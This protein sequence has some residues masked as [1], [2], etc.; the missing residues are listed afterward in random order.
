MAVHSPRSAY[1]RPS[2]TLAERSLVDVLA[3]A[4]V[5]EASRGPI[6]VP[7]LNLGAGKTT[8]I[9]DELLFRGLGDF[10]ADRVDI[11]DCVVEHP[12]AGRAYRCSI[13]EMPQVRS[14]AYRIA[15]SVY[16]LEH[17]PDLQRA[18]REIARVLAPSGLFVATVPNPSALEFLIARH[19]STAFHRRVKS[20]LSGA[21]KVWETHYSY[22][23]V[24]ALLAG[25]ERNG[26]VPVQTA[27]SS[28]LQGYMRRVPVLRLLAQC[29]D[30]TINS[31]GL[32]LL[33]GNVCFVLRKRP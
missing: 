26:L 13:E 21:R 24:R 12:K 32:W 20:L 27:Y 1:R 14:S 8:I 25:F 18:S 33:Q 28:Y 7:I 16:V 4:V 9:E 22:K 11:G 2:M 17:V 3:R 15:F 5:E 19:T 23:S 31:L 30:S 10:V 6:P 29:Y